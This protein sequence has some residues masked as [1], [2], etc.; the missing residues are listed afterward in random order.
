MW[1]IW[2]ARGSPEC[3]VGASELGHLTTQT[4]QQFVV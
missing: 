4:G 1:I 3:L 2:L